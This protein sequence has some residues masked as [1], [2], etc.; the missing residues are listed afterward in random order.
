[1]RKILI[2]TACAA[3]L[4]G[5]AAGALAEDVC[6]EK[7]GHYAV[8]R[9]LDA[10][11]YTDPCQQWSFSRQMAETSA[12]PELLAKI[13]A[14]D[15]AAL[16]ARFRGVLLTMLEED[17]GNRPALRAAAV[18]RRY[19]VRFVARDVKLMSSDTTA[20]QYFIPKN[21]V[22]VNYED[23]KDLWSAKF[24]QLPD[25]AALR[26]SA[27][28]IAPWLVHELAH[29][30]LH[31][32]L[33]G[34]LWAD[35]VEDELVPYSEQASYLMYRLRLDP[36]AYHMGCL[37]RTFAERLGAKPVGVAW[38]LAP[39]D[40]AYGQA[41]KDIVPEVREACGADSTGTNSW[42]LVR[43]FAGGFTLLE[44]NLRAMPGF[45]VKGEPLF[46]LPKDHLRAKR[47]LLAARKD[48]LN[49]CRARVKEQGLERWLDEDIASLDAK[50][51][52]YSA[53]GR[54]RELRARQK[55][56]MELLRQDL[57]LLW[58]DPANRG[59]GAAARL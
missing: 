4:C 16:W 29:A 20:A 49:A 12:Q 43:S 31:N 38:W 27:E 19:D 34:R 58:G 28:R 35:Y 18:L 40:T 47:A 39:M 26:L 24:P 14:C 57:R 37:D 7:L 15:A 50:S 56:A 1:M 44:K 59:T 54:L 55:A 41:A 13:P 36:D 11:N 30:R 33:G 48:V 46:A 10:S 17:P 22:E 23:V 51:D 42:F 5:G 25:D 52:F 8:M 6:S 21:V 53:G 3:L 45:G 2:G 9:Q 32:E